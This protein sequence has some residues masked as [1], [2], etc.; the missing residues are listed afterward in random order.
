MDTTTTT[1]TT[2]TFIAAAMQ[3]FGRLPDQS[4]GSFRD[5]LHALTAKD[6]ADM[7]PMLAEALGCPVT[8]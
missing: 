2:K 6:R 3:Y 7:A 1:P 8:P 5:E 4:L